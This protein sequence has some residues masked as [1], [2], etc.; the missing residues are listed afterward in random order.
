MDDDGLENEHDSISD[1]HPI[2]RVG[3]R[4]EQLIEE[5]GITAKLTTVLN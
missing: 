5:L 4:F 2:D 1:L 3:F